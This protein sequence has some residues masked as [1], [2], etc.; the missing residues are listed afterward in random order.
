MAD[1]IRLADANSNDQSVATDSSSTAHHSTHLHKVSSI[2]A[3]VAKAAA[4]FGVS[5]SEDA[6]P[7]SPQ[8]APSSVTSTSS[9]PA[10][11]SQPAVTKARAPQDQDVLTHSASEAASVVHQSAPA[12]L[13][14]ATT[15]HSTATNGPPE[16]KSAPFLSDSS[17]TANGTGAAVSLAPGSQH[18]TGIIPYMESG[19]GRVINSIAESVGEFRSLQVRWGETINLHGAIE[20]GPIPGMAFELAKLDA[21]MFRDALRSFAHE[22]AAMWTTKGGRS[23]WVRPTFVGATALMADAILV[24]VWHLRKKRQG[25]T[26]IQISTPTGK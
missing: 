14:S 15:F 5:V 10:Q 23:V 22:S 8:V 7:S 19:L 3:L 25:P 18:S 11:S 17:F 20:S 26:G 21:G 24:G 13:R 1:Q 9:T 6:D 12:D 2:G 4:E 16:T